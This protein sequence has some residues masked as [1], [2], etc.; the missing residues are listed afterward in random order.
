[1]L[2]PVT[3]GLVLLA[4]PSNAWMDEARGLVDQLQFGEAIS[5]LE[6]ARQVPSLSAD[7]RREVLELL[8][9]CQ[10]AEGQREAAEGTYIELLRAQ[11]ALELDSSPKVMDVFLSAKRKLYPPDY[12]RLEEAPSPAGHVQLVLVDPW[13]R[14]K[15]LMRSERRDGGE[16]REVESETSF[17]L[18]VTRGGVLEWYVEARGEGGAVVAQV[19]NAA[20][21][22]RVEAQ[23]IDQ[24]ATEL[25]REAN[26]RRAVGFVVMGVAVAAASVATGLAVNG[27]KLRQDA[28]D[29]SRAPG[30]SAAS[31][32]AAE[33]DG[34][35]Q[36]TVSTGLFIGAGLTLGTGIVLAW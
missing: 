8:A 17:P 35:T 16:W 4:A 21:P 25:P 10:V 24:S 27:W 18:Q 36:Q 33:L 9:Y 20:S 29:P 15:W 13:K 34:V 5:R 23:R 6:V 32:R 2:L 12:V 19:A 7:Q 31:A 11:P 1:M 28:R 22:R 14:V 26:P 30:D 3:I